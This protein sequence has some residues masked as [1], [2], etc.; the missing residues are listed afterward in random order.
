MEMARSRH[1]SSFHTGS[2]NRRDG[3]SAGSPCISRSTTS[4]LRAKLH[5]WPGASGA[6]G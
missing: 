1:R 3:P 6:T 5:R 2:P 4:R